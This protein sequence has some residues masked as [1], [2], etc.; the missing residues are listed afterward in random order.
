MKQFNEMISDQR[1]KTAGITIVDRYVDED[2]TTIGKSKHYAY[3]LVEADK[4]ETI[5]EFFSFLGVTVRP[6]V[7]WEQVQ[8]SLKL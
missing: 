6:V 4:K 5:E 3:F 8:K 2:C 7:G 1:A